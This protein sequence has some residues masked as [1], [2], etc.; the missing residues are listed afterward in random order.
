MKAMAVFID[1]SDNDRESLATAVAYCHRIGGRLDVIHPVEY[2]PTVL[3]PEAIILPDQTPSEGPRTVAARAAFDDV[4]GEYPFARW[5]PTE[6]KALDAIHSAAASHDLIVLERLASETGPDAEA[7]RTALFQT[8]TPV[9]VCPPVPLATAAERAAVVWRMNPQSLRAVRAAVPMLERAR[10]VSIFT[11]RGDDSADPETLKDYLAAHGISGTA[12]TF[13]GTGLTARARA[14]ALLAAI[15][16]AGA[17]FLVMGAYAETLK[18][19]LM[20]LG[21]ATQKVVTATRVP[22]LVAH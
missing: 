12:E 13:S 16:A 5:R 17:D 3:P 18:S 9:L 15:D 6:E 10:S 14:R 4:C 11:D 1:G 7:L 22:V 19:S 2:A 20:G 21:R 8:P